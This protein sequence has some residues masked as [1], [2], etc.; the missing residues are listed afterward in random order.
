MQKIIAAKRT[1]WHFSVALPPT[2]TICLKMTKGRETIIFWN[3]GRGIFS[4]HGALCDVF[5]CTSANTIIFKKKKKS[6]S[7]ITLCISRLPLPLFLLSLAF[8]RSIV[9]SLKLLFQVTVS[10]VFISLLV[11]FNKNCVLFLF[12]ILESTNLAFTLP[13][14]VYLTVFL[15]IVFI[16]IFF[17]LYDY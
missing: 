16:Y 11:N 3:K 2:A 5:Y 13:T 17:F 10:V 6:L 8:T 12:K 15:N 14:C 1:G 9:M 7:S 4:N